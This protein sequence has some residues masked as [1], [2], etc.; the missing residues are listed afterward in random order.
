MGEHFGKPAMPNKIT[1]QDR[2]EARGYLL[3]IL[4]PGDTVYTICTHIASSGMMRVLDLVVPM[5]DENGK[6]WIR[7][8][9][10]LACKAA[11]LSWSE[12]HEGIRMNGCGMDMGFHAVYCLGQALWPDGT[13]EPHGTRNGEPDSCG[14]YALKQSWL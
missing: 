4:K 14:G 10:W 13:P 5:V 6:P 3:E 12:K 8:I 2:E 7:R 9:S 11:R 1:A